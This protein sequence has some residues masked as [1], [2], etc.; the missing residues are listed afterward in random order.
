MGQQAL[1]FPAFRVGEKD[2]EYLVD[3]PTV[4]EAEL[5]EFAKEIIAKRFRRA[6]VI[7]SPEAAKN[8]LVTQLAP[9]EAEVFMV[10]FLDTRHRVIAAQEMFQ[11]TIDGASVHPREVVKAALAHNAAAVMLSHNHPSGE[12]EPSTAD[13]RITQ[14]LKEALALVDVRVLDHIVVGGTRTVSLAE[15]GLV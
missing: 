1:H 10:V 11:G 3:R 9:R 6:N 12:P 15:R 8:Y 5:L 7:D 14:R 2:G 4:T 13:Q